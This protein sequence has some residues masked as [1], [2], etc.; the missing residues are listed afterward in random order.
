M[1]CLGKKVI[2][3]WNEHQ[4]VGG[5][6]VVMPETIA[7]IFIGRQPIM[8]RSLKVVGYELLYRS[9]DQNHASFQDGNVATARV[10]A[11]AFL[12]I[13]LDKLI[14]DK[15]AFINLPRNFI[16]GDV[17]LPLK[18]DQ[19]ILEVLE[20]VEL[21][22]EVLAALANLAAKGYRLAMDDVVNADDIEPVLAIVDIVK[23]DLMSVDREKL[24]GQVVRLKHHK[25]KLLA[26]KVEN[27]KELDWCMELGFDLFQGYFLGKP[28]LIREKHLATSTA[29]VI[30]IL[31]EISSAEADVQKLET[32]MM[33]DV[34]LSFKILRL[35]NSAA[36]GLTNEVISL[37]Q[38][39]GILGFRKLRVMLGYLL[40]DQ[41][42]NK[43]QELMVM[44]L[45]RG[46]MAELLAERVG[47]EDSGAG[48]TAGFFSVLEALMDVPF[49][50]ILEQ[51]NLGSEI[52][53]ALLQRSGQLGEILGCVL[54]Y[55]NADW[56]NAQIAG[57]SH[58]EVRKFYLVAVAA[59]EESRKMFG[60]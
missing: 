18:Q 20:D 54:A 28:V 13:G 4:K 43:P 19:L 56:K 51:V 23:I 39:L 15:L 25:V 33:Q 2:L 41:A 58:D 11:N 42:D 45:V 16:V 7:E 59:A 3:F 24:P 32:L 40:L 38:G 22:E 46:K 12:E 34:S 9:G 48:Y 36:F 31:A 8:D 17:D 57:V 50:E 47:I 53:S 26:E 60:M 10:I 35:I 30:Q 27:Q 21:D 55:E 37:K 14:G 5:Q 29:V 44:A 49:S 6:G 1:A 52:K